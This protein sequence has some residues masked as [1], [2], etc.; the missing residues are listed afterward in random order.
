MNFSYTIK[1]KEK[2]FLVKLSGNLM[3]KN[4]ANDLMEEIA[5][6]ISKNSKLF[7]IDMKEM[8]YLNSSGLSV[9]LNILT[10]SRKAGGD[11]VLC[12]V[13]EKVKKVFSITRLTEVFTIIDD[14]ESA[15][16]EK[17]IF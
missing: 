15:I 13:S 3:E 8:E 9:F 16:A 5:N 7:I 1:E 4:Q 10:K 11:T 17:I 6:D 12:H 2:Y 14:E